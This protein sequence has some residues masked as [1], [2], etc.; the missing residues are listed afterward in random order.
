MKTVTS[1]DGTRIAYDQTGQGPAVILVAGA[2]SYRQYLGSVELAEL[3][4]QHFAVI[5]YDRRGRGDSGDTAPYAVEREIEDL[6]ALINAAGGSA[7]VWGLSSGAVLALKAA[8]CGLNIKKLVLHEPPFRVDNNGPLPPSDFI[9]QVTALIDE[10]RRADAIKYFMTKGMGAPGIA[11][12]FMRLM[13][14]V[15]KR[16]M[17]VAHTLPYDALLLKG[18]SA[19]KPLAASDWVAVTMPT[20]VLSGEKSA[21]ALRN[22]AKAVADVLP[23]AK[24]RVLEGV[25]HTN[26]NMK[27]VAPA[28]E[29]FFNS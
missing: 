14:G 9:E 26:V 11:M 21:P 17:A 18:Y 23:N 27:I 15:W 19:G 6:E 4:S 1:R 16:L 13:P 10:G 20:L 22:A 7:Y 28:L 8:A 12:V 25:S 3:L 29:E 5:N 2:F 24:T